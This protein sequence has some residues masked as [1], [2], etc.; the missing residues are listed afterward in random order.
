MSVTLPVFLTSNLYV[1][2]EPTARHFEVLAGLLAETGTGG[3]L[4]TDAHL[5]AL[6]AEHNATVVTFDT[7]FARFSGVM[8]EQPGATE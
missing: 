6:A 4:V 2:V 3:N 5:A 7:D 8:S 1:I